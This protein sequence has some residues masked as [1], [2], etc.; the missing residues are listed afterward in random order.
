MFAMI[1]RG[2]LGLLVA[3]AVA[4]I[5]CAVFLVASFAGVSMPRAAWAQGW[6]PVQV[7]TEVPGA[8]RRKVTRFSSLERA[9]A[10]AAPG[11]TVTLLASVSVN[12]PIPVDKDLSLVI[13][14][15]CTVHSSVGEG[16]PVFTVRPGCRDFS[17]VAEHA[18]RVAFDLPDA[19]GLI[20]VSPSSLPTRVV[21]RGVNAH[22]ISLSN[23]SALLD[24]EARPVVLSVEDSDIYN[25]NAPVIRAHAGAQANIAIVG[26]RLERIRGSIAI[27][28]IAS[29]ASALFVHDSVLIG[30][31]GCNLIHMALPSLL[32]SDNSYLSALGAR[33]VAI[34][35]SAALMSVRPLHF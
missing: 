33:A 28:L 17:I 12:D 4:M 13:G 7:E 16:Q 19:G 15:G 11:D 2:V 27:D 35:D 26:S 34:E 31:L 9:V 14:Q 25:L 24:L 29:P 30:S 22:D 1:R 6:L 32:L 23:G 5:L 8:S 10:K 3:S 18:S 21:L 20:A